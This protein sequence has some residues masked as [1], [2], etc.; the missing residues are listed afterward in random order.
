MRKTH[1]RKIPSARAPTYTLTGISSSLIAL[2][3]VLFGLIYH[4]I[5]LI[6]SGALQRRDERH[7]LTRFPCHTQTCRNDKG[8]SNY[9]VLLQ[10]SVLQNIAANDEGDGAQRTITLSW[11]RSNIFSRLSERELC[12]PPPALWNPKSLHL[13][14][15]TKPHQLSSFLCSQ[16]T[17]AVCDYNSG[18]R[19]FWNSPTFLKQRGWFWGKKKQNVNWNVTP[20]TN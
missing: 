3:R 16:C 1:S 12:T 15:S 10:L 18:R 14:E 11:I 13:T 4:D 19:T 5:V 7:Q 2:C 17:C 6:G 9:S 20:Q 8:L